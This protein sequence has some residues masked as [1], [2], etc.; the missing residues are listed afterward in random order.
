M[1]PICNDE[2][3]LFFSIK[4]SIKTKKKRFARFVLCD[5]LCPLV[6]LPYLRKEK[7]PIKIPYVGVDYNAIVD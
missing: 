5:R 6:K 1:E 7:A 3:K 4:H 2:F